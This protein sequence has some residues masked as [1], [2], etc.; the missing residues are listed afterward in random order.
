MKKKKIL[1]NKKHEY[2]LVIIESDKQTLYELYFS[3]ND[4]WLSNTQ[5]T[6]AFK[7]IDNGN[8]YVTP[9]K[10]LDYDQAL[11]LSIILKYIKKVEKDKTKIKF[12]KDV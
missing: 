12:K 5:N 1:I 7:V 10:N 4:C 6:L 8:Y 2:N 9:K 11:Y 3:D